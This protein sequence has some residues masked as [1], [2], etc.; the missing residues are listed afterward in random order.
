MFI[1]F[2]IIF[3]LIFLWEAKFTTW[4]D[5]YVGK[6]QA[7]AIKGF[8]ILF[9]TVGHIIILVLL[10][11]GLYDFAGNV[12]NSL[13]L[14]FHQRLNQLVVVM[15]LFFSG[16]GVSEGIKKSIASG[17]GIFAL[18]HGEEFLKLILTSL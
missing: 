6:E 12:G 2:S 3:V 8:W 14:S 1:L 7:N 11:N 16:Y 13:E 9:L 15:F 5:D 17:G 18:S 4:N 10:P